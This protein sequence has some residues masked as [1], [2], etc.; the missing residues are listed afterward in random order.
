MKTVILLAL[1]IAIVFLFASC[2]AGGDPKESGMPDPYRSGKWVTVETVNLTYRADEMITLHKPHSATFTDYG[3][4]PLHAGSTV[5][6]KANNNTWKAEISAYPEGAQD[7]EFVLYYY[8]GAADPARYELFEQEVCDAK[9]EYQNAPVKIIRSV[10]C[11]A[12]E[13][14][15]EECFVGIEFQDGSGRGLLGIRFTEFHDPL[16]DRVLKGIFSELFFAER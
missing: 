13:E 1:V 3:E 4:D 11:K 7:A 9:I 15:Q 14:L 8:H 6:L 2:R 10:F 16:S 5:G 12:G